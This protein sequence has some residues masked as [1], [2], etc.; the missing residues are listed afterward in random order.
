MNKPT[1]TSHGTWRVIDGELVDESTL[2]VS[3]DGAVQ[4]PVIDPVPDES[5]VPVH[6]IERTAE[7]GEALPSIDSDEARPTHTPRR[8]T[9]KAK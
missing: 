2:S 6:T 7:A 9:S 8:K 5:P 4:A 3:G 1:P